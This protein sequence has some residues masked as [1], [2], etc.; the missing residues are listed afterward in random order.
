MVEKIP[1]SPFVCVLAGGGVAAGDG[2]VKNDGRYKMLF[3]PIFSCLSTT[4]SHNSEL[5]VRRALTCVSSFTVPTV[6]LC[7]HGRT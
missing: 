7:C 5:V 1:E 3:S 4:V 2:G 6:I